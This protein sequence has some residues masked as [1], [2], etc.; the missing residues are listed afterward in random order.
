ME[1]SVSIGATRPS[2][3]SLGHPRSPHSLML[4]NDLSFLSPNTDSLV[5][6]AEREYWG[7]G[8]DIGWE[9]GSPW[10][11]FSSVTAGCVTL[12]KLLNFSVPQLFVLW[13]SAFWCWPWWSSC[14]SKLGCSIWS[15]IGR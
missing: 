5:C 7:I 14:E 9:L 6:D 2:W 10:F 12:G 1:G 13:K 11:G 15:L 3:G 4:I 8:M